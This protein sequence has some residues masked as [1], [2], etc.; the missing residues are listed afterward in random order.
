MNHKKG[1]NYKNYKSLQL[2]TSG[3]RKPDT[4][5]ASE[6]NDFY[7]VI[8]HAF[9]VLTTSSGL[10]YFSLSLTPTKFYKRIKP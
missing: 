2:E 3:C 4:T 1:D 5:R 10:L 7:H 9:A 8:G 6:I